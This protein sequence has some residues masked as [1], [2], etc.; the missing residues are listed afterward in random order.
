MV[1]GGGGIIPCWAKGHL[2]GCVVA[3]V[4]DSKGTWG[5]PLEGERADLAIF[6]FCFGY[7]AFFLNVY[8]SARQ[9]DTFMIDMNDV[10]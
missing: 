3:V 7:C 2:N 1:S 6:G 10:L 9:D 8:V 4:Q 5:V